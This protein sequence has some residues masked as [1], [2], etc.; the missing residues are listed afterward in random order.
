[1]VEVPVDDPAQDIVIGG[2]LPAEHR[3]DL[4]GAGE[5]VLAVGRR[6]LQVWRE[7]VVGDGD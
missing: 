4:G 5:Q 2:A 6:A 1:V 3:A 7:R